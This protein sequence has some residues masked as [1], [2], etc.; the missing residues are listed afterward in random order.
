LAKNSFTLIEV[1]MSLII[2]SV[3]I[4]GF[5]NL[6]INTNNL[7]YQKLTKAYNN[8]LNNKKISTEN[9]KFMEH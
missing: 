7:N 1:M 6:I 2:I 3:I 9:I 5:S 8:Y 4:A